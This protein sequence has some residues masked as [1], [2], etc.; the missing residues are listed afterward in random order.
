VRSLLIP[1]NLGKAVREKDPANNLELLAGDVV[2]IFGVNDVPVPLEKRTQF[3]SI[4]GEVKV[5]GFYQLKTG[6]TLTQLIQR[7]G[8]LTNDAF[9]YGTVFTRESTRRQQQ[10][11]LDLAVRRME[12]DIASQTASELQNITGSDKATGVEAQVQSQRVLAAR[13]KGLKASGRISL[14]MTPINPVYPELKLED[15][16]RIIVP[17]SPDFIGVVGAVMAETSFIY[18]ANTTANNYLARA[19][20]TRDAEVDSAMIIRADGS[21]E[22]DLSAAN[23]WFGRGTTV[24]TRPMYPGDTLFV[25]EKVDRRTGYSKFIQG[26]KDWTSILYQFGIGAAAL[27][28]LRQ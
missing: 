14:E 8:G 25:P 2:T 3:V 26:A 23:S 9:A 24:L 27:K 21:V 18:R 19:G 11:N 15:G 13:L 10:A 12:A 16:D 1:F 6:E 20:A 17:N 22:T 28:T 4:G 7:A 5:P